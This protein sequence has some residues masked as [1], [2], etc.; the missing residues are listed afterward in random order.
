VAAGL[1]VLTVGPQQALVVHT[2]AEKVAR[3][4][5]PVAA[6]TVGVVAQLEEWVLAEFVSSGVAQVKATLTIRRKRRFKKWNIW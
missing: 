3:R 4:A 6:T 5:E 2:K 1:Q